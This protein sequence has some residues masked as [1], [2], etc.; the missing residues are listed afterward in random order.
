MTSTSHPEWKEWVGRSQTD[1]DRIDLRHAQLMSATLSVDP[2]SLRNG[3]PLP[4][5]WHWLYFLNGAPPQQLGAD[6]HAARGGFL[7]PIGLANRMW[8]GG[9]VSF[10]A[11]L[12][13]G[14]EAWK[15]STV[16]GIVPKRGKSGELV[17]VTVLHE[18]GMGDALCIR[19]EHDIVYRDAK[20]ISK[21]EAEESDPYPRTAAKR[22]FGPDA[23]LLFRY[24]ALTFNGHRIHYDADYCR[25]VEGYPNIV[26]HGP[27]TATML[28]GLAAEVAG[29]PLSGFSYRAHAPAF[30]GD[31][32]QLFA[33]AQGSGLALAA[34]FEDGRVCM[35]ARASF[36]H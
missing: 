3:S 24:S 16:L 26:I 14:A 12:A 28:C 5:L 18:F 35:S 7:P 2:L 6:G 23:T 36:A 34:R 19:E 11:P 33:S 27:L 32:L 4:H 13:V 9:R 10:M 29:R 30:L 20:T 21:P 8:A 25:S 17:F 22:A 15:K 31:R 1:E